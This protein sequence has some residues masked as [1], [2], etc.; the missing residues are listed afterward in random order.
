M[1]IMLGGELPLM[2]F[3]LFECSF[4]LLKAANS[5]LQK[6]GVVSERERER[7]TDSDY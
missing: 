1:T 2:R 6:F 3:A 5:K 7:P 4:L